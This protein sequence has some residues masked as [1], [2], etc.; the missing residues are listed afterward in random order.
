MKVS[1]N[2]NLFWASYRTLQFIT[3]RVFVLAE[4]SQNRSFI[5]NDSSKLLSRQMIY[6]KL[7]I[8]YNPWFDIILFY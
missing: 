6:S 5:N 4:L 7:A 3:C 1:N 2:F 8:N